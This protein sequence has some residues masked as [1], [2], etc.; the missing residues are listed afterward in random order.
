MAASDSMRGP[1]NRWYQ[2]GFDALETIEINDTQ[3]QVLSAPCYLATKFEAYNSRGQDNYRTS[4]DVEDIIYVIDNRIP[5]FI[6]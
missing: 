1:S 6:S 3:I 4:H 2:V 5:V